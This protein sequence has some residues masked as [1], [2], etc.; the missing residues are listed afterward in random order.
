[1]KKAYKQ[2]IAFEITDEN[3]P[4]NTPLENNHLFAKSGSQMVRI[5]FDEIL[6]I[7]GEKEYVSLHFKDERLLVYKRMKDIESLLPSN[8]MR[9]HLSFIINTKH[10]VK[11][12]GNKHVFIGA[13]KI[14]I[15][16]TYRT[17]IKDYI[18]RYT[19]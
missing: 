7:K 12:I 6:Y 9:V 14:P 10:I 11:V 15:G 16:G 4:V 3:K 18:N 2:S 19:F 8:F 5:N 1:M 13:E 17:R